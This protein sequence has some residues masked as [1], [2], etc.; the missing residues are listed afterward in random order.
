MLLTLHSFVKISLLFGLCE[1][2]TASIAKATKPHGEIFRA[3]CIVVMHVS[4]KSTK[5][6]QQSHARG[7]MNKYMRHT[8]YSLMI[9]LSVKEHNRHAFDLCTALYSYCENCQMP[10]HILYSSTQSSTSWKV[11]DAVQHA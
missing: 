2:I 7:C 8:I 4:V 10:Q 11:I 5:S 9:L 1:T 3:R 6:K